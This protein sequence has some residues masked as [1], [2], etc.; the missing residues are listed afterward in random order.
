MR[1][2][3]SACLVSCLALT[4][5]LG[6]SACSDDDSTGGQGELIG[7]ADQGEITVYTALE[8]EQV[9]EYLDVFNTAYPNITI[10]VVRESTGII[11]AKLL[12]EKDNP[13]ADLVWGTAASSLLV[14][15]EEGMLEPFAPEG[16]D[17]I[18]P[19]FKS[20]KTVPTWV[21][22]DVWETAFTINTVELK[23]LGLTVDDIQSYDDLL[24]PELKGKIVMPNPSSSGTG[25]LTVTGIIQLKGKNTD[26]GWDFLRALHENIDQY[27]HSGSKP[28]KMAGA[29]ETVVGISFG[30]VGIKQIRE[31][32]PVEVVFPAEGSGWDLEANALMKKDQINRASHTFLN[33]AISDEAMALYKVNYPIIANGQG[34]KYE[35]FTTNPVDQLIDNDLAWV[36]ANRESILEAWTA[37]FDGKSAPR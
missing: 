33:W 15:D 27:V 1:K 10:N 34:G 24:R 37:N 12:A 36:A 26:D 29:G 8:D 14:L 25:L 19:Q 2:T 21:G 31:G 4:L 13:V 35:G 18:L 9:E 20:T 6:L 32:N 16:V 28:A 7:H 3:I 30:Y 17:S 5:T 22:I 11:T 23:K